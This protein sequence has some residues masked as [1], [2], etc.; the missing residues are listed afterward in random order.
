MT[1]G[2]VAE[3]A[4]AARPTLEEVARVA[5]VS[6][7]TV[8]RVINGSPRVSPDVLSVVERAI[9]EL[10][11]VPNRA[12]RSLA[13]RSTMSI[14]LVVPEDAH[15]FFGDPYFAD[16]VQGISER[17][18]DS[19]YVLNLQLTHPSSPS[20]K[21]RRY[22]LGGNVDGALVVSHHSGDH[23]LASLGRSLPVVFGGRPLGEVANPGDYYI[24]VG[25]RAGALRGVEH[26]VTR[27][28][29]HIATITGPD[30]MPASV[31]RERGWRDALE[32][33]GL[34]ATRLERGD[35]TEAGGIRAAL[36]LVDRHPDL[37]AIFVASDLM[38]SGALLALEE[39]GL[40]VP[41]DV[42]VVG[43]DDSR[44]AT[45]GRIGLTTVAQ[46]AQE[47][48]IVMAD[49]LLR[50]LAGERPPHVTTLGTRLVE[51]DSA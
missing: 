19:D 16:V 37:D 23:F 28:R 12:A 40:R 3:L 34:E 24:D 6:R 21:T 4:G 30:D 33:A 42:A 47:M 22:L 48:G 20:E 31:D 25:N 2:A 46:P 14:A 26:L 44:Y 36:A 35:F 49:T 15:R 50:L 10:N 27:G 9:A 11:Y 5:G 43:F 51:R 7:A 38:A 39:R 45:R 29:R 41:E 32:A 18:D 13:A 8:S 17:L 1:D